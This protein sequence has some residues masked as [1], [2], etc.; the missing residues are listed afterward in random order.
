MTAAKEEQTERCALNDQNTPKM[1][2]GSK[3]WHCQFG[4]VKMNDE[5]NEKNCEI[6]MNGIVTNLKNTTHFRNVP[7]TKKKRQKL[8]FMYALVK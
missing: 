6:G 5:K 1:V 4:C 8:Y 7:N 3:I 2:H